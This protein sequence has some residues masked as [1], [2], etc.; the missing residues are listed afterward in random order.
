MY[1]SGGKI[2]I[3]CMETEDGN[4]ISVLSF[5]KAEDGESNLYNP[6]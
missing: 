4:S 1:R 2:Y 3:P 5:T 6:S